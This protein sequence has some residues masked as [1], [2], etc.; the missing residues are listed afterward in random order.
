MCDCC[1]RLASALTWPA[2]GLDHSIRAALTKHLLKHLT[3]H[4]GK[5]CVLGMLHG[6]W[7]RCIDRKK[8]FTHMT[9]TDAHVSLEGNFKAHVA[10]W[11]MLGRI[12]C[13]QL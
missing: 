11:W 2:Y 3:L 1:V 4:F 7:T 6:F 12:T 9:L 5:G 13:R 10:L 8:I